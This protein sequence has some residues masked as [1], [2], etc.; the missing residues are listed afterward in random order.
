MIGKEAFKM[1]KID[2]DGLLL[3]EL[4][5]ESFARSLTDA[6]TSSEIFI[7]RFMHSNFVKEMDNASILLTNLQPRDIL[8]RIDEE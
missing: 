5:A 4:Q 7:R 3:C 8:E 2:R 1:R 6:R